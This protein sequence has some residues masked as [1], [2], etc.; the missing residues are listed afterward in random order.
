[1]TTK[2]IEEIEK[3]KQLKNQSFELG[4]GELRG[5]VDEGKN[6]RLNT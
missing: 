4:I 2:D 6:P 5:I 1:M 3:L